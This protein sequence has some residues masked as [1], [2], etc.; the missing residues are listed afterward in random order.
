MSDSDFAAAAASPSTL[1][2]TIWIALPSLSALEELTI[3]PPSG[4]GRSG[5]PSGS[6][7]PSPTVTDVPSF[8]AVMVP[9]PESTSTSWPVWFSMACSTV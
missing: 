9:L 3:V 8:E 7:A 2:V 5:H 6:V 1:N 4:V